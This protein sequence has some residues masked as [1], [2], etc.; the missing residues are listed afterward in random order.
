M[1]PLAEQPKRVA[2]VGGGVAGIVCADL[3][4]HRY[5]VTLFERNDY[6]GGHTH[7]IEIPDGPDAG[8]PVDTGF[9]V[10]NDKTYPTFQAFLARLGV[11]TRLSEMSFGF[12]C[13]Q[14]GQVYAGTSLNGLFARRRNLASP[15]FYAFLFELRRFCKQARTDLITGE[16][17]PVTLGEYLAVG[18]FSPF[19]IQ[20]YLEPMAAAIWSTPT[21][22]VTD[23]PAEPFLR[24]F[25]NHGL[26]SLRNR[27]QWQTVVGGSHAYVRSFR[28]RFKG[29]CHLGTPVREVKRETAGVRVVPSGGEAQSFDRVVLATHADQALCL[30]TD[31]DSLERRLLA[32]WRYQKNHAVLHTDTSVLPRQR[33]AWAAWNFSREAE[34]SGRPVFVTYY[35]NRLQGFSAQLNYCV[36][37]NCDAPFQRDTVIA[38]MDY[39]HPLYTNESM[40]TQSELPRLNG[41][42]RTFFCGS[43]F[44]YGFHEDAVKAGVAAAE[45]LEGGP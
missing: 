25:E 27:P 13:R 32:P 39:H 41:R 23:F 4:Q 30:I 15:L 26:L 42:N 33:Q 43:Y 37:L 29:R 2:V 5:E 21:V 1:K 14:S 17:P 34:A 3:L 7:T 44:G 11:D 28:R 31:A 36:T 35:M 12:Q 10:L 9:I 19:M 20:N 6:L 40:A 8:L 45:A 16:V 38:E 22:Q 18:R 24:F